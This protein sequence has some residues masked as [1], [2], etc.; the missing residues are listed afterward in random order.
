MKIFLFKQSFT[1]E[2][3][4]E[5]IWLQKKVEMTKELCIQSSFTKSKSSFFSYSFRSGFKRTV[6]MIKIDLDSGE[7]FLTKLLNSFQSTSYFFL[8]MKYASKG[9][10]NLVLQ[11]HQI[12][13]DV[14]LLLAAEI[15][16]G[17]ETLRKVS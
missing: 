12:N 1:K 7:N 8:V 11:Y 10:L 14:A 17:L 5:F 13:S 2:S 15:A 4:A 16:L 9:S 3:S 6:G